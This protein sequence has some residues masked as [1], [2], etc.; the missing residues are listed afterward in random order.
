VPII[1]PAILYAF[2]VLFVLA[3][4][5]LGSVVLLVAQNTNIVPYESLTF[6]VSGGYTMLSALNVV[7]LVVPLVLV[8]VLFA[9]RGLMRRAGSIRLP[10]NEALLVSATREDA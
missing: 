1:L 6:W 2:S 7:A 5:E 9:I 4:R 8:S 3:F 10:A